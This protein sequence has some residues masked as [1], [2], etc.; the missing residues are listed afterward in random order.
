MIST[1]SCQMFTLLLSS[2]G[3]YSSGRACKWEFFWFQG[4]ET[5]LNYSGRRRWPCLAQPG[6]RRQRDVTLGRLEPQGGLS[7]GFSIPYLCP[8]LLLT[9]FTPTAGCRQPLCQSPSLLYQKKTNQEKP[10]LQTPRER[11]RKFQPGHVPTCG[12]TTHQEG[13]VSSPRGARC[14]RQ[15]SDSWEE[16]NAISEERRPDV[17]KQRIKKST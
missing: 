17:Q 7:A 1:F 11:F 10:L 16:G 4:S 5:H 3:L 8:C 12:L 13:K 6:L 2:E 14:Q 15:I 9:S